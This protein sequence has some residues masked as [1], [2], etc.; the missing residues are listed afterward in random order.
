VYPITPRHTRREHGERVEEL[1][2]RIQAQLR[3][4]LVGRVAQLHGAQA[5]AGISNIGEWA[6]SRVRTTL[7]RRTSQKGGSIVRTPRPSS[8]A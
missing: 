4:A 6:A 3:H 2:A 8:P 1:A 7:S 5:P